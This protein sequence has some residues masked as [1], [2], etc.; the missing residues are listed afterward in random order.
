VFAAML[1]PFLADRATHAD[2]AAR[3][4]RI[5]PLARQPKL[6]MASDGHPAIRRLIRHVIAVPLLADL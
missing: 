3:T 1:I 5:G 2:F 6:E 4:E